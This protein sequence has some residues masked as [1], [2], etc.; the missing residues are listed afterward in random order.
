MTN[1]LNDKCPNFTIHCNRRH[2]RAGFLTKGSGMIHH[3]YFERFWRI[4]SPVKKSLTV[5]PGPEGPWM[6][7]Q[8]SLS[9][10]HC[11]TPARPL[12]RGWM[13]G[14]WSEANPGPKE[15]SDKV[16]IWPKPG[17]FCP[18]GLPPGLV[19]TFRSNNWLE[20]VKIWHR[21]PP[22]VSSRDTWVK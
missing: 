11:Q 10:L 7:C 15:P 8:T 3:T 6:H 14:I 2:F 9:A 4:Y 19:E 12:C 21:G 13:L 5:H 17:K 16:Q 18:K 22:T 20:L 1:V